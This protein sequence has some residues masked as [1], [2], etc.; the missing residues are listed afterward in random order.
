MKESHELSVTSA[1]DIFS[2]D[3]GVKNFG[4]IRTRKVEE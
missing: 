3:A 1:D 2:V 4:E